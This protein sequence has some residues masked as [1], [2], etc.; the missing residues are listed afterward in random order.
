[1][2]CTQVFDKYE[3]LLQEAASAGS[4]IESTDFCLELL[5]D[6]ER[7]NLSELMENLYYKN[8]AKKPI[9]QSINT[10]YV[11]LLDA[12]PRERAKARWK[13]KDRVKQLKKDYGLRKKGHLLVN[14]LEWDKFRKD[15]TVQKAHRT[16]DLEDFHQKMGDA[17]WDKILSTPWHSQESS[18]CH[19]I[20]YLFDD[21]K[22]IPYIAMLVG[23]DCAYYSEKSQNF[24]RMIESLSQEE[25]QQ[26]K[27]MKIPGLED[28]LDYTKILIN[29]MHDS[30]ENKGKQVTY[31]SV[32]R[33]L[34]RT[35]QHFL[36][37]GTDQE[38]HFTLNL[39]FNSYVTNSLNDAMRDSLIDSIVK[40]LDLNDS[41]AVN[42]KEKYSAE[43]KNQIKE[44]IKIRGSSSTANLK[45]VTKD[46]QNLSDFYDTVKELNNQFAD[47][48]WMPLFL[49]SEAEE[50]EKKLI[51]PDNEKTCQPAIH[52]LKGLAQAE[53]MGYFSHP[54]WGATFQART[55]NAL[56][57]IILNDAL[58]SSAENR[59]PVDLI[60]EYM[61]QDLK[62]FNKFM[63]QTEEVISNSNVPDVITKVRDGLRDK[64][65]SKEFKIL[66]SY[67]NTSFFSGIKHL[68]SY[69][70]VLDD[71]DIAEAFKRKFDTSTST[72]VL[73]KFADSLNRVSGCKD[74]AIPLLRKV[75]EKEKSLQRIEHIRQSLEE[76]PCQLRH[77]IQESFDRQ[78]DEAYNMI[79]E[80][81]Q[82][83]PILKN[84]DKLKEKFESWVQDIF[85][86]PRY[87]DLEYRTKGFVVY[88]NPEQKKIEVTITDKDLLKDKNIADYCILATSKCFA[89]RNKADELFS[90]L[91]GNERWKKQEAMR[92]KYEK[93]RDKKI[94]KFVKIKQ[95][96]KRFEE[97]LDSLPDKE[98]LSGE[99]LEKVT[100]RERLLTA[101]LEERKRK[102]NELMDKA[103][104]SEVYDVMGY[105]C[106]QAL[107]NIV[108]D[109]SE[110]PKITEDLVHAIALY[111]DNYQNKELL[112]NMLC[113]VLNGN[114]LAVHN[115]IKNRKA[116]AEFEKKGVSMEAWLSEFETNY[117][118]ERNIK[119]I[120]SKEE[121][122]QHH[123]K[124]AV[125]IYEKMGVK[126]EKKSTYETLMTEY[127][128]IKDRTDIDEAVKRDLKTQLR[129]IKSLEGE[130]EDENIND[131]RVYMEN[132]PLKV[133][134]MGSH[135]PNQSCLAL[136]SG[137]SWA[138][139]ANAADIN[140]R[141]IYIEMDDTVIARKLVCLNDD[142]EI[143]QFR[144]YSN[145]LDLDLNNC[146][147]DYL[148]RL[149]KATKAPL[150][151]DGNV[152][153]ILAEE[154]YNDGMVLPATPEPIKI[155]PLSM[156][157]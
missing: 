54:K 87:M 151:K 84:S 92:Q 74:I 57:K 147:A 124:E 38:K 56:R 81:S 13:I 52:Y 148:A 1:M 79:R 157:S 75:I 114:P 122:R 71:E 152:S 65:M 51:T 18:R 73:I 153:T 35:C 119:F 149:S 70:Q 31:L 117:T 116:K 102:A 127:D 30:E 143:V 17:W 120:E 137:N 41:V 10:A 69:I 83:M 14:P 150:G 43:F 111:Y 105:A 6:S 44:S 60:E 42:F 80:F 8:P 134:Q 89:Q 132:D 146:F 58:V 68:Y 110:T 82:L 133:L 140:K 40:G 135:F 5:F 67:D 113:D 39:A 9:L 22:F 24:V 154:W 131:V 26:I 34:T 55:T 115:K 101:Q 19:T 20:A 85:E 12:L 156:A 142:G 72:K 107:E 37:I 109:I 100:R 95:Q 103:I 7:S 112:K 45:Q 99:E 61:L 78:P 32:L 4:C 2:L 108:G 118:P 11:S 29:Q 21:I 94:L 53:T 144:T 25:F 46:L 98:S 77:Y 130:I 139:V 49:A 23:E 90:N 88:L 126:I 96:A 48:W 138:A 91:P 155:H 59:F 121:Q 86:P 104:V 33:N 128:K 16:E 63:E 15:E 76:I 141:V 66:R 3:E 129:G 106:K 62:E 28:L 123:F 97:E 47:D 64:M 125:D 27:D 36:E 136:G 145:R 93:N 50:L